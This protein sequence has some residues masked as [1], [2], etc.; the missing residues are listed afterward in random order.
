MVAQ[1]AYPDHIDS[2]AHEGINFPR[3]S[4]K[5]GLGLTAMIV[6][7]G[8]INVDLIFLVKEIPQ[9]GQTVL[10]QGSRTEAGGK[11]ANQALAAARD[12]A[13]VVMMGAVGDDAMAAIALQ[14]LEG[15]VDISRLVRSREPTGS[16]AIMIDANGRNMIAVSRCQPCRAIRRC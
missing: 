16:A 15:E 12:G 2:A 5:T 4:R 1:M 13:K 14:N 3:R 10:A 7:F 11:G 9:A 8:S 6:T